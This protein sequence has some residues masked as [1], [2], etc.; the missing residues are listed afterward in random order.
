MNQIRQFT[1]TCLDNE[2]YIRCGRCEGSCETLNT[3]CFKD[4][5]KAGC[6]CKPGFVRHNGI[7]IEIK[8]CPS[9]TIYYKISKRNLLFYI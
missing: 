8:A 2:E 1:V 3:I 6:Y 4:C 7:C 5:K 9:E